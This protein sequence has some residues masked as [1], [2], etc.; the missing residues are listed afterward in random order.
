MRNRCLWRSH[1]FIHLLTN[2]KVLL[3]TGT[4]MKDGPQEI[5]SLMN[6]ILPLTQQM[7]TNK[8]F[9]KEYFPSTEAPKET[10]EL[11]DEEE[12]LKAVEKK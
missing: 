4:P 7:P 5:A 6:L 10:Y 3:L 2:K 8:N 1:R 11:G 12:F 9:L